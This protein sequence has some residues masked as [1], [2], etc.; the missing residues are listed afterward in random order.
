MP[1][2]VVAASIAAP[3]ADSNPSQPLAVLNEGIQRLGLL[4]AAASSFD[5]VKEVVAGAEAL[6]T[7]AKAI[8]AALAVQND[9]AE[10]KIRGERRMGAE[11][12]K[13]P[14]NKGGRPSKKTGNASLPVS[15]KLDEIGVAPMQAH[16]WQT[17]ARLT[18]D[19]FEAHVA[20]VKARGAE[21]T[22]AGVHRLVVEGEAPAEWPDLSEPIAG[23]YRCP[24]CRHE[25]TGKPR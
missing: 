9:A 21:L 23:T 7:F 24:K 17:M 25:W 8:G 18:D 14:K 3:G 15:P 1:L 16:R 6:R 12:A 20:G 13:L 5:E 22:S 11:L 10:I 4:L 19:Q 2:D